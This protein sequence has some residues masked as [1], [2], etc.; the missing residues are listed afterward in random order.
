MKSYLRRAFAVLTCGMVFTTILFAA[1]KTS[2]QA[3]PNFPN[4]AELAGMDPQ[5][6]Q[7]VIMQQVTSFFRDRLSITNEDEWKVVEQRLMK[8]VRLKAQTLLAGGFPGGQRFLGRLGNDNPT[9]RAV[10]GL[11]GLDDQM[12]EK[13][14]LQKAIEGHAGSAELKAATARFVEARK[15]KQEE[16]QKAEAEL[17]E[18]LTYRQEATLVL[19]SILD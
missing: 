4:L 2:A 16:T 18:V 11:L 9:V 19:M 10:M 3:P 12:P 7:Q 6:I 8:L 5:Q 1:T 14:A 17:R 15:R 13:A